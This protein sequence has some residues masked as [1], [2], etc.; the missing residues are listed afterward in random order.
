MKNLS[1]KK[2]QSGAALVVGLIILLVMT[3]LGVNSMNS[4]R[5]ELKI[6]ANVKNHSTAFQ[7]AEAAIQR[8]KTHTATDWSYILNSPPLTYDYTP[9]GGNASAQTTM[10]FKECR[11]NPIGYGLEGQG[12]HDGKGGNFKA[13]VHEVSAASVA[14]T[15]SGTVVARSTVVSGIATVLAGCSIEP[16]S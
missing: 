7:T 15:A 9:A 16:A 11:K 6:A 14:T 8:L 3:L 1:M 4:T 12:V 10:F 5:S 2:Q 13:I